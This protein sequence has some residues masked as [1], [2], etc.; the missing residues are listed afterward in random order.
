[1]DW[2]VFVIFLLA[3][4]AAAATGAGFAPGS[5]YRALSKPAW[6]PPNGVFPVVWTF[7]YISAAVAAA[8]VANLDN[9]AYAMAFW[10]MQIA[11]N[12]LWSPV[13]FGLHRIRAALGVMGGLWAA[14]CGTM[15]S[16]FQLD[17]IAGLLFVPYLIWVTLAAA[18]NISIWRRNPE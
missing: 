7:L 15:V 16:F 13:F 6:T 9:N 10:G 18:L 2:G 12:T 5:W 1:M 8:R 14:V 3:C 17:T 11:F 4:G